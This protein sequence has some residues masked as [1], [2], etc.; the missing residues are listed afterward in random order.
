[1]KIKQS[2]YCKLWVKVNGCTFKEGN[3]VKEASILLPLVSLSPPWLFR[4]SNTAKAG[5]R[6]LGGACSLANY[7]VAYE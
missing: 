6:G 4:K 7:S 1:M 2:R 3:F 5:A